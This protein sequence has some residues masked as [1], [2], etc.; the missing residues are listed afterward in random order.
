[1]ISE[2]KVWEAAV[3][4][5]DS[6]EAVGADVREV[7]IKAW[8]A[9]VAW[10]GG[11]G[12]AVAWLEVE[13]NVTL[14]QAIGKYGHLVHSMRVHIGSARP[15]KAQDANGLF[16]LYT[17]SPG[18]DENADLLAAYKALSLAVSCAQPVWPNPWPQEVSILGY[19]IHGLTETKRDAARY[20]WLRE[21]TGATFQF[22]RRSG[23]P[24]QLDQAIDQALAAER[25]GE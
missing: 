18:A 1:M 11:D 13:P 19:L 9:A 12:E 22:P 4:W 3:A 6:P 15:M 23:R 2:Q 24:E 21:H 8:Q 5:A 10:I 17:H 14:A 20:R 25:G 7:A 16:P